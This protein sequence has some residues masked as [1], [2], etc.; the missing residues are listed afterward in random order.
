MPLD[1]SLKDR[2][3]SRRWQRF[4]V[5]EAVRLEVYRGLTETTTISGRLTDISY[6]GVAVFAEVKLP[7][8]AELALVLN[9]HSLS[10][11]S[12]AA[13]VRLSCVVRN[14][15]GY[16]YGLEFVTRD[17]EEEHLKWLRHNLIPTGH[18]RSYVKRTPVPTLPGPSPW[19]KRLAAALRSW[20]HR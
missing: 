1:P 14:Q 3:R 17:G 12:P 6:E 16:I 9:P 8:G 2:D 11:S 19:H 18:V 20:L 5:H 10:S 13:P 7:I 15:R 4:P